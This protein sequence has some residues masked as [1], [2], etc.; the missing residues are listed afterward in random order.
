MR[1]LGL[2]VKDVECREFWFQLVLVKGIVA[3]LELDQGFRF[4]VQV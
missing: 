1:N 2:R 4:Q 3:A